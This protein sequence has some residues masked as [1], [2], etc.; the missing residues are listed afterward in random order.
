MRGEEAKAAVKEI[1]KHSYYATTH[2]ACDKALQRDTPEAYISALE[3]IVTSP[4]RG[5]E[6]AVNIIRAES[7]LKTEK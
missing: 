2:S 7:A 6:Y 4:N 1:A 3:S 5:G